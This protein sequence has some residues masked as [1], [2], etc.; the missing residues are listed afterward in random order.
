MDE[1][2]ADQALIELVDQSCEAYEYG[3]KIG[4][5]GLGSLSTVKDSPS[6]KAC[7][8]G[9]YSDNNSVNEKLFEEDQAPEPSNNEAVLDQ[10]KPLL[11]CHRCIW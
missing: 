2:L 1:K 9:A 4:K 7:V 10:I 5:R 8:D 11:H 3:L 6:N